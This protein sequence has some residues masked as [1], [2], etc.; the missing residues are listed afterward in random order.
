V[1]LPRSAHKS[2]GGRATQRA[3]NGWRDFIFGTFNGLARAVLIATASIGLT[4][5]GSRCPQ[6]DSAYASAVAKQKPRKYPW[7]LE[8]GVGVLLEGCE[9]RCPSSRRCR[10]CPFSTLRM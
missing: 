1:T 4:G 8:N 3:I 2:C 6:S 10:R 9:M 5:A 7:G